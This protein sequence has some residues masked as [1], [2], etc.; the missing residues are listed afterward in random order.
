ARARRG[1]TLKGGRPWPRRSALIVHTVARATAAAVTD[2][3]TASARAQTTAPARGGA[4]S[5]TTSEAAASP[6]ATC[7]SGDTRR[8]YERHGRR[9]TG[10]ARLVIAAAS[11]LRLIAAAA[12]A[13]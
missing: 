8:T 10:F 3:G 2:L 11:Q 13:S 4:A 12:Q 5:T 9:P 6:A 7:R 1:F